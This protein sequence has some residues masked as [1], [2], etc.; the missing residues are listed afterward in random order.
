M[1]IPLPVSTILAYRAPVV[2]G[3]EVT[4][5]VQVGGEWHGI[6]GEASLLRKLGHDLLGATL[7]TCNRGG[8]PLTKPR[9]P[10]FIETRNGGK[11]F[12]KEKKG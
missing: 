2:N 4:V 12:T 8:R 6:R 11:P 5:P 1:A 3:G 10:E 7:P 9:P